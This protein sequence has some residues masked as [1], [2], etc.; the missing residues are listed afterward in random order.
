MTAGTTGRIGM[1]AVGGRMEV[2]VRKRSLFAPDYLRL[3]ALALVAVAVHAWLLTHS[4]VTARDGIGFARYALRLQSPHDALSPRDFSRTALDVVRMEQHPPG[5]PAL[6][7]LAAKGVRYAAPEMPLPEST[8]LATQLVSSLAGVLL[9]VPIYLIGRSLFGRNVGFAAALLFQVLPV[10]AHITSDGMADG[11]YTLVAATALLFGVR[12]VRRPGIGGFLLCGLICG[13]SYLVRPEGLMVAAAVAAVAGWLGLRGR[14]PRGV[15]LGRLTALGVGVA[16]VA[17]P[18]MILIG[19]LTRKPTGNDLINRVTPREKVADADFR[20]PNPSV[21]AAWWHVPDETSVA[22]VIAPAVVGVGKEIGKSL[23]YGAALLAVLGVVALR[24]RLLAEPGLAA[25]LA[26]VGLNCAVLI[27]LGSTGYFV[28]GKRT[29]YIAEHHTL[30]LSVVGCVFA[31]AAMESVGGWL[32]RRSQ[33]QL[34]TVGRFA[35]A[36]LLVGLAATALP[37][38]LKPMHTQREGYKHAGRFLEPIL[39]KHVEDGEHFTLID[40]FCWTE[41]Y[42]WRTL[43]HVP[44]DSENPVAIYAVVDDRNRPDDHERLPRLDDARKVVADGRAVVIYHWPENVDVKQAK[45]KV[46]KLAVPK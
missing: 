1:A 15:T 38:T 42:A 32:S 11:L 39:R 24:R 3:F 29:F 34:R 4:P 2:V 7:W 37:T 41:W 45:V 17:G 13:A 5:Y 46:Y 22:G 35:P 40:P 26:F 9:V 23:H 27:A 43:Y 44:A 19:G 36:V 31:A 10:P 8:L 14:W 6:V 12:A 33:P 20:G 30:L 21:F 18:Y 25:L 28:N 16:L